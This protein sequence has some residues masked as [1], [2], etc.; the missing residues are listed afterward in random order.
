L[1]VLAQLCGTV[2]AHHELLAEVA[3]RSQADRDRDAAQA[4]AVELAASEARQREMQRELMASRARL[5]TAFDTARRQV[6]RDLH[7]GAQPRSE[8]SGLVGLRDRIGALNGTMDIISP[9]AGGTVLQAVTP[10]TD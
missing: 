5:V 10:L 2:I 8:S 1:S 6:T 3:L 9:A 7:D 4:R